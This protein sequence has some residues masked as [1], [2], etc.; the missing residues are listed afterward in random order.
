MTRQATR[1]WRRRAVVGATVLAVSGGGWAA[2][3]EV[4]GTHHHYRLASATTGDVSETLDLTGTVSAAGR[5]DL[6]AGTSGRVVEVPVK[7][8]QRVRRGAVIARL[9]QTGLR[10]D[11]VAARAALAKARAQ[12]G[13]DEAAQASAVENAVSNSSSTSRATTR[14]AVAL[15]TPTATSTSSSTLPATIKKDQ[16]AVTQAQTTVSSALADAKQALKDETA[17]C[18]DTGSAP[19]ATPTDSASPTATSSTG[20]SDA[21]QSALGTV[22][23]AQD[24]VATAQEALQSALTTLTA[25]LQQ[26][27]TAASAPSTTPSAPSGGTAQP[28]SAPTGGGATPDS[29]TGSGT[30]ITAATLARDQAAIDQAKAQLASAIAARDAAVVRAPAAG[31]VRDLS[32]A[33]GDEVTGGDAVAVLVGDGLTTVEIA[34]S[35][36]QAQQL[37]TG[38]VA[39]VTPAGSARVLRGRVTR[40]A[41]VPTSSSDSTYAVVVTL[42]GDAAGQ[43][44]IGM[45]VGVSVVT[46]TAHDAVTVP[47]S[48]VSDGSVEV[49]S[50]GV[51]TRTSVTVGVVGARRIQVVDGLRA[52]EQVVLADLDEDLPSSGSSGRDGGFGGRG[53]MTSVGGGPPVGFGG[54]G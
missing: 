18:A 17:V 2:Y 23:A 16:A 33:R 29:S 15:T 47:A 3:A 41:H 35:Q 32:V 43:P 20:G 45:P 5:A 54:A 6:V 51:A 10:A 11:V 40:I 38:A 7:V 52:G 53:G 24:A 25:D 49:L 19:T 46:G 13:T 9:D 30:S 39:R 31:Q 27:L 42:S 26:A 34:A 8:G 21:C 12:L 28:P 1:R 22:E 4:T 44:M 37:E 50:D 36:T 14:S 48:A